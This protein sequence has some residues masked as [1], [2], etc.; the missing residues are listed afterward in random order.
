MKRSLFALL[1]LFFAVSAA[2]AQEGS[3]NSK[4]AFVEGVGRKI[5]VLIGINDYEEIRKLRYA[6]NDVTAIRD[7]LYKIG[8][9]KENVFCLV[10]GETSK[11]RPTKDRILTTIQHAAELAREGDILLIAMTG[12]GIEMSD[13]QSRFCSIET[14][15]DNLQ[16]TTVP[17]GDVFAAVE[18]SRATFKL[19]LVDACR[20]DPFRGKAA[21]GAKTLDT[22][23]NP[24]K[25]A[26]LFQSS[27][28][29][30]ISLEDD[31]FKQGIFSHYIVEGLSGKATDKEGRVTLLSLSA[32][33]IDKT[34][35]R[36]YDLET[37]RQVPY[38]KG[39]ITDFELY[40][41]RKIRVNEAYETTEHSHDQG[42]QR[43]VNANRT[44]QLTGVLTVGREPVLLDTIRQELVAE[45]TLALQYL[46]GEEESFLLLYG[47]D[48]EPRLLPLVLDGKQAELFSVEPGS[49]ATKKLATI[50]QAK[51]DSVPQL[52]GVP[53]KTGIPDTET[54]DKLHALWTV[55]VPDEQIRAKITDRKT[56]ARL[57]ILPD[58]ALARFP[59]ESMVV[60]PD[61][62]NPRYLLDDG[63][64]TIYAPSAT[65]YYDLSHRNIEAKTPQ[66]LT[67]GRPD[68]AV[69]RDVQ[70]R[71]TQI[72][73]N[74]RAVMIGNLLDIPWAGKETELIEDSCKRNGIEVK[75]FNLAQATEEN[76]RKNVAGKLI[77]H[78]A[79]RA[80]TKGEGNVSVSALLLTIGDPNN[81][82]DDGFLELAEM[83]ELDLR[84]CELAVL[85]ACETNLGP[86]QPGEGTW[87]LGRGMM[88]AGARRV[89]A[90]NW[91]V[92][93]DATALMMHY[94]IDSINESIGK[95]SAPD[96]AAA[97]RQAKREI[98][99]AMD[100]QAWQHPY[101]WAPF[102]LIGPN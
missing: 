5:A 65:M 28:K 98:R 25:G 57:L 44:D 42:F 8:F 45:K 63:P 29:G 79:C 83:F 102:V 30:E 33:V 80:Q 93:D 77:V 17:I 21:F 78:I 1:F 95:L 84:A 85:S 40:D 53:T 60:K 69:N 38:L 97:L 61:A 11:E 99:N 10:C 81:P 39:E 47:F 87:S 94:F 3:T 46:I 50:L 4:G 89:V 96:Y 54:L 70:P 92:A 82:K 18:N 56:L 68:Y 41:T 101:Y 35:R 100:N 88:A 22:L 37:R 66:V 90:A 72:Q 16:D 73:N 58:R 86:T 74:H 23:D 27:A 49:L 36:A 52:F 13:G 62:E 67:V 20:N 43:F 91:K 12:H 6:K 34:R 7:Q 2:C 55:L 76:V 64:A 26:L 19:M 31:E 9:E 32:Y 51:A 24:P 14:N 75:R 59:F 48:T 71:N 15:P